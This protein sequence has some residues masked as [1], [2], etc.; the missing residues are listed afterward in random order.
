[1]GQVKKI[2]KTGEEI[3]RE[4]ISGILGQGTA[5]KILFS[6]RHADVDV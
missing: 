4:R 2:A 1:V 5:D 3:G 6:A